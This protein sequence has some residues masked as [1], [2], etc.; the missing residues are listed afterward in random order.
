[1]SE[2]QPSEYNK[3]RQQIE[4]TL[5]GEPQG[6]TWTEIKGRLGLKQKVPNNKW[7]RMMERDIGLIRESV[8]GK[9]VVWRLK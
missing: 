1:M 4:E 5:R 2:A 7:V 6:L 3:F 8:K 9:G